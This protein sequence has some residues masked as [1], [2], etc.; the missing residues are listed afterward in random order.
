M[1]TDREGVGSDCR[2]SLGLGGGGGH[3]THVLV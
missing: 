1:G 2:L 3:L